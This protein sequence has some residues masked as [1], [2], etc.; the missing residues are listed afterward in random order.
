LL[1]PK[2]TVDAGKA[3]NPEDYKA[4]VNNPWRFGDTR[5]LMLGRDVINE[6]WPEESYYGV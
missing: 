4:N 1:N 5:I 3:F 6:E 2:Y